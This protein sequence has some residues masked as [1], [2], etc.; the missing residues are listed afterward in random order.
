MYSQERAAQAERVETA[1]RVPVPLT[2]LIGRQH[3]LVSSQRMLLEGHVRLLALTGPPGTAKTRLASALAESTRAEFPDGAWLVPLASVQRP[4]LVLPTIGHVLDIRQIGR[5][6]ILEA[7]IRAL[8]QR[9]L[10]LVLDNFE[11]L[12]PAA[13]SI[14][15]LLA[16][17]PELKVL[18]TSRAPLH[19]SGEHRFRV[20]PLELPSLD[21][22]PDQQD[23]TQVAAVRL[24]VQRAQAVRPEFTLSDTN[25]RA[26][27]EICVR[28][29]GLP[30]A[31]EL[32]AARTALLSWAKSKALLPGH[33]YWVSQSRMKCWPSLVNRR[34]VSHG[35]PA[36]GA[37]CHPRRT[38]SAGS[39]VRVRVT[40][41]ACLAT[42]ARKP[43]RPASWKC[44]GCSDDGAATVRSPRRWC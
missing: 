23:L 31:I 37:S 34:C 36:L 33:W 20:P 42:P 17:C 10:L 24:F 28:L 38:S 16:S 25:A 32:A 43:S 8:R 2:A 41:S 12:L 19:V 15:E 9:A 4:E 30:L 39:S 5:R 35:E 3:E 44:C 27:A 26:V 6:P 11:H 21:P 1:Y 14:V 29:D 13:A 40:R 18:A 22:L 7:L